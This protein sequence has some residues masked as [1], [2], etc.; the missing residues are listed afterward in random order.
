VITDG[1]NTAGVAPDRVARE[2][3][4]K[5]RG[6]VSIHFIAFDTSPAHFAFLSEVGGEVLPAQDEAT[7]RLAV[8]QI[9][10]GEILAEAMEYGDGGAAAAP[11]PG[12]GREPG[13]DPRRTR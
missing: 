2:I 7:L 11:P 12:P 8:K 4:R 13:P 3:F 5:S 1:A 6:G 10:E 9:Y